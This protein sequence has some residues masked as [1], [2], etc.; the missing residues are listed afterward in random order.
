[1]SDNYV[2]SNNANSTIAVGFSDS[3]TSISVATGEGARFPSPTGGD[4]TLVTCQKTDGTK[5][6]I[7]IVG[8]S[9]DAL[10]VGIP[11][12]ASAN[13]AGRNYEPI[14]GMS[15]ASFSVGDVVSC[16]PTAGMLEEAV[17][18]GGKI[19]AAQTKTAIH[20]DDELGLADSED[21]DSTKKSTWSNIKE[22][23]TTVFNAIYLPLAGGTLT[24]NLQVNGHVTLGAG[25]TVVFEG[26]TDDA[27]ETTVSAGDPTADRTITLPDQTG[28]VKV[29]ARGADI[30][31][32]GT[33]NLT[34]ATG[35]IVDVTG[36]TAITAI[37]LADGIER[38][39]RFTGALTLTDGASL[40]LPSG[41]NITTAA[42]DV[43][44]FRGYAAGVVRCTGYQK[45]SG[46]PLVA[47]SPF[48]DSYD[49]GD[50]TITAGALLELEHGLVSAPTL[51]FTLLHCVSS[52]SGYSAGDYL[53][54]ATTG[55]SNSGSL[56]ASV[57]PD[58]TNINVRFGSGIGSASFYIPRKDNG[59]LSAIDNA[60]WRFVVRAWV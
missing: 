9:A 10:T 29:Q 43:A 55:H 8:R 31:S 14:Y 26:T 28:T 35:D 53:V 23:L 17:N 19:A 36:T 4:Y 50:Q 1:M 25:K 45:A 7:C 49:S 58:A 52:D 46:A 54:V 3:A 41:A 59:T 20:D 27:Y 56:G 34:T 18:L 42:G 11:G 44:T 33:I 38:M 30:A 2:A 47:G 21:S 57:V 5:E 60:N 37:T 39:V 15:A 12:S 32:A 48:S 51:I 16:R 24:G 40:V 6:I 13:V 22:L